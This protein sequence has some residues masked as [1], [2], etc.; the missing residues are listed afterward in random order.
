YSN[1]LYTSTTC[2][3]E[4]IHLFQIKKIS[5]RNQK[6]RHI[7]AEDIL[8]SLL[9]MSITILPISEKNLQVYATLPFLKDHRDP[10]DSLI[11][12]QAIS[13]KA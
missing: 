1:T 3:H 12:A 4:L 2:V 9:S 7:N 10:F 13:D 11:I 6:G 5:W 8:D